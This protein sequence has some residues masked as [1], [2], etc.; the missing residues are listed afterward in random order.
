[1]ARGYYRDLIKLLKAGGC[2]FV[3]HGVG[4]HEIWYSPLTKR[5]FSVDRGVV[6]RHTANGALKDAGLPKA[7]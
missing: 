5:T 4:D 1:M 3:R 2:T 7:F 6:I